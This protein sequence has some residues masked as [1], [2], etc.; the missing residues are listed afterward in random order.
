MSDERLIKSAEDLL[1][2]DYFSRA[3]RKNFATKQ[4]AFAYYRKNFES[5][6]ADP[7][8]FFETSWYLWQNPNA[9]T[10]AT[11]LDH[12]F[13][14]GQTS[15]IDPSPYLDM[16]QLS[17]L[18]DKQNSVE[19]IAHLDQV[20]HVPENGIFSNFEELQIKQEEFLSKIKLETIRSPKFSRGSEPKRF[21]CFVQLGGHSEFSRWFDDSATR[22]WDLLC[23]LYDFNSIEMRFGDMLFAQK[24]TKFTAIW[25]IFNAYPELLEHY[26]YFL[27]IDDDLKFNFGDID[28]IFNT[29]EKNELQLFQPGLTADSFCNWPIIRQPTKKQILETNCVEIMMPGFSKTALQKVFPLFKKS[30]SGFGLDFAIGSQIE[31][32]K[33]IVKSVTAAHHKPI[34]QSIGTYYQMLRENNINS[35][36]ELYSLIKTLNLEPVIKAI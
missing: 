30:I 10:F 4:A 36:F 25:S 19:I 22:Q 14:H 28:N 18:L 26:D 20:K 35:K 8:W 11:P 5:M 24:G 31:G 16:N 6:D 13:T 3:T 7:N 17:N 32:K 1:D 23:N 21:L 34:D 27:F 29:A 33:G 2:L 12:F 15:I 9:S